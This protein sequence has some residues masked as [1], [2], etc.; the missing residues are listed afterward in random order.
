MDFR[1]TYEG[2]LKSNADI[3]FK[4]DLRKIFH[5]Q[6]RG[7]WRQLPLTDY[8]DFL[9]ESPTS[10]DI[11]IIEYIDNYKFAPLISSKNKLIAELDIVM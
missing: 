11:S 8:K 1:L 4:H 10:Q 2:P 7:L 6:L 9:K 3:K 5:F